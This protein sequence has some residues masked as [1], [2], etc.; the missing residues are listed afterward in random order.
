[1]AVS[2]PIID[3]VSRA[4]SMLVS[5]EDGGELTLELPRYLIDAH[6]QD[7]DTQFQVTIDGNPVEYGEL[8][9]SAEDDSESRQ[10]TVFV[11]AGST[12]LDIIGTEDITKFGALTVIVVKC[13]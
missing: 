4:L 2:E 12:R 9:I 13:K 11:P 8:I 5:T 7:S 6:Q 3:I 1:V 10:L